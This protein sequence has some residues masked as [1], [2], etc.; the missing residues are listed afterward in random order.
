MGIKHKHVSIR[1]VCLLT[2]NAD[3][4]I[5]IVVWQGGAVPDRATYIATHQALLGWNGGDCN[6]PAGAAGALVHTG[7]CV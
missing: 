2:F 3:A 6:D 7:G 1:N 5:M 4:I